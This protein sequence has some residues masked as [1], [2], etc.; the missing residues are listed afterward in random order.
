MQNAEAWMEAFDA[1][2]ARVAQSKGNW[3]D[4]NAGRPVGWPPAK[5]ITLRPTGEEYALEIAGKFDWGH[6]AWLA[7]EGD[8]ASLTPGTWR[9][10]ATVSDG[11]RS[12]VF[13]WLVT[14][15]GRNTLL[16]ATKA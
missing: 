11:V 8:P 14:N 12:F 16:S 3:F 2:G 5:S 15:P 4:L 13:D 6:E 10:R 9:V 1:W 7:G